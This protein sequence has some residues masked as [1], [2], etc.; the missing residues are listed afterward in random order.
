MHIFPGAFWHL[1]CLHWR[2]V[3]FWAC[4]P[5][6]HLFSLCDGS[7][8]FHEICIIIPAEFYVF[9]RVFH[10]HFNSEVSQTTWHLLSSLSLTHVFGQTQRVE[11]TTQ[12]LFLS[13]GVAPWHYPTK[14][15]AL[16]I[17]RG[18]SGVSA[19]LFTPDIIIARVKTVTRGWAER[20]RE[21]A[22]SPQFQNN[23]CDCGA[24]ERLQ[25]EQLHHVH[26]STHNS[27]DDL[28]I[29]LQCTGREQLL[30][31]W[32]MNI[33]LDFPRTL[34]PIISNLKQLFLLAK[35]ESKSRLELQQS[36]H[37]SFVRKWIRSYFDSCFSS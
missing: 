35:L 4:F 11:T 1:E 27:R 13:T 10:S 30:I 17:A 19:W 25:R 31:L 2:L 26:M 23:I 20:E 37:S 22:S 15:Q 29:T 14:R 6:L 16:L 33:L 32:R 12:T 5:S 24:S 8:L 3:S 7:L 18:L 21:G 34:W 28:E 36:I 9:D